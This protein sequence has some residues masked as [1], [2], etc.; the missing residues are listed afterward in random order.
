MTG[1]R[2]AAVGRTSVPSWQPPRSIVSRSLLDAALAY[3]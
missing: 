1:R 2:P 3:A